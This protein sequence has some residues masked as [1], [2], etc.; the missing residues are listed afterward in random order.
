MAHQ[1]TPNK[2]DIKDMTVEEKWDRL[3]DFFT[4]DHAI[5]YH[6]HKR[7]GTVDEWVSDTVD[8]YN[9]AQARF[10]GPVVELMSKAALKVAPN[11][12][13][14]KV[15]NAVLN[16]DQQ[17]HK[18]GEY[19]ISEAKNGEMTVRFKNCTRLK[20]QKEV[21]KMCKLPF[22]AREICEVEKMHTTHPNCPATKMGIITT[23]VTWEET[24]CVWSF[25]VVV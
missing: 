3:H 1:P 20:K 5:S 4:M 23:D 8:A 17:M 14:K 24:G 11:M 9:H 7:L 15:M 19:E 2:P 21:V 6:T 25:K 22:E 10:L 13:L 16:M 12:V 18:P